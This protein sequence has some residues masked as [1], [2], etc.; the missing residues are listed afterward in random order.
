VRSELS[1][2]VYLKGVY[3]PSAMCYNIIVLKPA[4]D[5]KED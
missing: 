3:K 4:Y 5:L 1:K 2:E